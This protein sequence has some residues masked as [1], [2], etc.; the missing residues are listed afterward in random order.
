MIASLNKTDA[1]VIFRFNPKAIAFSSRSA[2]IKAIAN[3]SPSNM[4]TFT[5]M[6]KSDHQPKL[7]ACERF[8]SIQ[9]AQIIL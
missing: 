5:V 3:P 2:Q 6:G 9:P 4:I 7:N 8:L 1:I